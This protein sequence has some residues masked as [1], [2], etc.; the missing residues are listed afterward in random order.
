M[1]KIDPISSVHQIAHDEFQRMAREHMDRT[2]TEQELNAI[3]ESL[4]HAAPSTDA[5]ALLHQL[6]HG[7]A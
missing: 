5:I 4:R 2:F 6:H 3:A 7:H 1:K